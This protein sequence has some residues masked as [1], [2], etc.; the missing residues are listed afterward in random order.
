MSRILKL[1]KRR[2]IVGSFLLLCASGFLFGMISQFYMISVFSLILLFLLLMNHKVAVKM[3]E[4][5]APFRPSSKVRNVEVLVIGDVCKLQEL[6]LKQGERCIKIMAPRRS[7][8]SSYEILRHT[9]SILQSEGTVII[10]GAS[11]DSQDYSLFDM[12]HFTEYTIKRLNLEKL[13]KLKHFPLLVTPV[14]SV[15]YLLGWGRR[16]EKSVCPSKEMIDFCREREL[17][18]I[19]MKQ[20]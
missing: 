17:Q 6:P 19:Y 12:A 18:L 4:E 2:I 3:Q 16:K 14:R 9:F 15:Q 5:V 7:L 20:A 13:Q 8:V 1:K 11:K 10:V